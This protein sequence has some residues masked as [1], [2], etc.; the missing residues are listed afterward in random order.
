MSETPASPFLQAIR[1]MVGDQCATA[2]PDQELLRQFVRERDEAAF[3]SLVRRHGAM[4]LSVCRTVLSNE[5]DAEDAF[6]ATFLVLAQNAASIR[7]T[8][9]V[10]SWLHGVAYRL[11]R[12]AQAN[13]ARRQKHEARRPGRTAPASDDRTW[14]EVQQVIHAALNEISEPYRAPLVLCY[15]EGKTQDEAA[16]LLGVS[17]ATVKNRLERGRAL[18]RARLVR[19]G[20][21]PVA[22]LAVSTWPFAT[23]SACPPVLVN[24]TVE[25]ALQVAAGSAVSSAVSAEVAALTKGAVKAMFVTKLMIL[26]AAL[27]ATAV[28]CVCVITRAQ[29]SPARA[30]AECGRTPD[31]RKSDEKNKPKPVV[32]PVVVSEKASINRLV[33]DTKSETV[34]T[35]GVTFEVAEVPGLN[36]QDGRKVLLPSSTVKLWDAKTGELKRSLGEEKGIYIGNLALSPDRKTAVVTTLKL[37]DENGK[38]TGSSRG[39]EEVRLLD[40]EKWELK[41]NVDSDGVA[42]LFPN[43]GFLVYAVAFSPDG[44]TLAIGGANGRV[45]GGCYLKLWDVQKEKVIGGT[46]EPKE[47]AVGSGLD[48]AV[49]SLAFSPDGKLL[50]AACADGKLRLFD[51]RTGELKKVWEDDSARAAWVVFSPDGKT[52]VSQSQDKTVKIWDVQTA[53]VLRT[54]LGNKGWVEAAAFSP[55]GK[56]FATGGTVREKD[57]VTK[58]EVIVWDAQ[59]W[60]L[61]H[62]L[63]DQ[64]MPVSTLSFSPD[65]KTLGVAG[66]SGG[67]DLKVGEKTTGEIKLFPLE[68]LKKA[69]PK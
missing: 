28:L 42:G 59:T 18:L 25:A 11:A 57:K 15:L 5:A 47:P 10:G 49:T 37:I 16:A 63:P 6:Q 43:T 19:R 55:D 54:L 56:L 8:A 1:R 52:L 33:W 61:K 58:G 36:G 17:K 24:S 21:G 13:H 14:A 51:G 22:V 46:K 39:T 66:G 20:L 3:H 38:A 65:G 31:D 53:K 45:E 69:E 44:K 40:A 34:V 27:I 32:K 9:S 30:S 4:V 29:E 68:S 62:T 60:E 2:A 48:E 7:K 64:T 35:V 12:K 41:R 26:C 50:A 67:Y 23:A